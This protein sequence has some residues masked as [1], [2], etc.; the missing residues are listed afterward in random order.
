M[1]FLP[2]KDL[3]APAK[4]RAKLSAAKELVITNNGKPMALMVPVAEGE[5]VESIIR[6]LREARLRQSITQLR[7]E[8]RSSGAAKLSLNEINKEIQT[9]RSSKKNK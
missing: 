4:L 9:S 6:A 7:S 1:D 5:D 8:A 3:K 2:V